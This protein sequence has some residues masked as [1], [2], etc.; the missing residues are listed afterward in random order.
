MDSITRLALDI[1]H[2]LLGE[3]LDPVARFGIEDQGLHAL[4]FVAHEIG[5]VLVRDGALR[6]AVEPALRVL[7]ADPR[8]A[9][10]RDS[11]VDSWQGR[12]QPRSNVRWCRRGHRCR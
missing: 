10:R 6:V 9:S 5:D 8:G 4:P 11:D 12:G 3:V 1:I 2:D 7:D